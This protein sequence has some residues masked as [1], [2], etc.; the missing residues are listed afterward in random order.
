MNMNYGKY[1]SLDFMDWLIEPTFMSTSWTKINDYNGYSEL[2]LEIPGI[3]KD[4]IE[5]SYT[6]NK[7]VFRASEIRDKK[8]VETYSEDFIISKKLDLS[9]ISAIYKNGV[10]TIKL[11]SIK[12]KTTNIKID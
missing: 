10:L 7:L 5:L 1:S 11:P 4:N 6:D 3:K 12:E 2:K 9:N 8:M